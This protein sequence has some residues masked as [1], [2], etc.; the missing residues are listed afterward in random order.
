M[1]A[2]V[3]FLRAL[4]EQREKIVLGVLIV[5]LAGVAFVQFRSKKNGNS[6]GNNPDELIK[7]DW[8][9]APPRTP[10]AFDVV[11]LNNRYP[12]EEYAKLATKRNVFE[13][14]QA[15]TDGGPATEMTEW[16]E[17]KVKSVFDPTQSGSYIAIIELDKRS[18]IVK[19]GQQFEGYEVL[20][21]DG[22]RRCLNVRK[23]DT[24]E[25]KEFCEE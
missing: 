4:Y 14:Q 19:E 1:D 2:I 16:A 9:P 24:K 5:A 3:A 22:V 11:S 7:D 12:L 13:R 17:L 23:R 8:T 21:I 25:E 15:A 6:N 20:R 18:R 10:G